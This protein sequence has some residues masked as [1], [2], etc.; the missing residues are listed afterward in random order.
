MSTN[1]SATLT[2]TRGQWRILRALC[3]RLLE[4]PINDDASRVVRRILDRIPV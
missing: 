4:G 3:E 2:L 1:V